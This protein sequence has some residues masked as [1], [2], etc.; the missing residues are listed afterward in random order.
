MMGSRMAIEEYKIH[1]NPT[2]RL[3]IE[4]S[5]ITQLL[6]SRDNTIIPNKWEKTLIL[7]CTE[8][9]GSLK[10]ACKMGEL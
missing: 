9:Y 8:S 6:T 10:K 3:A 7:M 2:S 1:K 4:F 5:Q